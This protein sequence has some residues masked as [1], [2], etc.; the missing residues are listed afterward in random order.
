[1]PQKHRYM[2][3]YF[4]DEIGQKGYNF[5][6]PRQLLSPRVYLNYQNA[7][8]SYITFDEFNGSTLS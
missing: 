7:L 4:D 8:M 5:L 2:F 1:M 6:L 3:V